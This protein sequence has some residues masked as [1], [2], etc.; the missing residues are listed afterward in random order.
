MSLMSIDAWLA[1]LIIACMIG[2]LIFTRIAADALVLSALTG[3][4]A[5][6]HPTNT[7]WKIGILTPLEAVSG[8]ANPGMLTV[9]V[10]FLVVC[11]LRE[12]GGVDWIVQRLL[13]RPKTLR[14]ALV[15]IVLPTTGMSAFLNNTPVVAMMIAAVS[16]WSRKLELPPSKFLIPLSYAAIL[17]GMCSLIGTSTNLVVFGLALN[18]ADLEIGMFDITWIG[19]PAALVG[20]A[21][22]V[23]LGPWLLPARQSS[24]EVYEDSREYTL[25]LVVPEGSWLIGKTIEQ[26]G[27]RNLPGCFLAEIERD[28]D[29]IPAVGPDQLLAARDQLVFVGVVDSI[30]ELQNMRGLAPATDQVFKLDSPRLRRRLFEV[31]LSASGPMIGKT[32][33]D[34]RFRNRYDA[35]VLAVT[36][37]GKRVPGKLGSIT[38][39]VGDTLLVEADTGFDERHRNSRDFLLVS[40]L[41]DSTPRRHDKAPI[42]IAILA[43]MV[44]AVSIGLV[45][46]LVAALVAAMLMIAT[47]CCR[48]SEARSNVD[49]T[50][51]VTIGGA[52]GVGQALQVTGAANSIAE[53]SLSIAGTNP[54][55]ALIIIYLLTSL[56]TEVITNNAA[57]AL[58][59]PIALAYSTQLDVNFMPFVI[60]VMMA[61][62]AS[63][64]T[65]LGYQTNLMVYGP[66][67]YTFTDFLKMGI[68]LNLT[69][70]AITVIL[71]PWVFP[72]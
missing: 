53:A 37:E 30:K 17:G 15:R 4:M 3:M 58:T 70:C 29:I 57:V 40:A 22:L 8:F 28:G 69:I 61:G 44:I 16:G 45:P 65:P 24:A 20:M 33:R 35:A 25:E 62:S 32:I 63:F 38:L 7:G 18:Q 54:W 31:V 67:G 9:G 42:A 48:V 60:T 46:M 19:L 55:V 6:P 2:C 68:P 39:R 5:I 23:F 26:A 66:G 50:V 52:L 11:G 56:A 64:A 36:R 71:T 13:G 47:R 21:Y 34:G 10:L 43:A 51:L 1:I 59:F 27:L 41:D 72:F 49:W 14:W 12:T